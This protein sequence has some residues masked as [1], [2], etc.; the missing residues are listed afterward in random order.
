MVYVDAFVP[1]DG[2]SLLDIIP[3]GG[4]PRIEAMVQKEGDGWLVPRLAPPP[5]EKFVPEAWHITDQSDLRW[6]LPRLR[7]VPLGHFKEPVRRKN[8]AAEGLPRTYIRCSVYP[9]PSFDRYAEFAR[10]S[11]GWRHRELPTNHLP[12]ITHP[13]EL[14]NLLLEVIN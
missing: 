14:A 12:F 6:V 11:A 2:E 4:R 9:N 10:H 5:W 3:P 8:A 7:P 13:D 1:Q